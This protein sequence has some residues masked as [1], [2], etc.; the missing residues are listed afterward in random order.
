VRFVDGGPGDDGEEDGGG[1]VGLPPEP[2]TILAPTE[3]DVIR[4][5]SGTTVAAGGYSEPDGDA[6]AATEFEVWDV[7]DG[8]RVERIWRGEVDGASDP[9]ARSLPEGTFEGSHR[10]Q[11]RL[12]WDD[13]YA[14]RA[15][16]VDARGARSDWSAEVFFRTDLESW[17]IYDT[18]RVPEFH[19]DV[20]AAGWAELWTHEACTANPYVRASFT[21]EG[22][23]YDCVGVRLKGCV[24]SFRSLDRK[25]G[26][27]IKF[28]FEE[29][30]VEQR[31]HG[32]RG[33]TLNNGVQD[34]TA[35]HQTLGYE[36][37]RAAGVPAPRANSANL[38]VNGELWGLYANV[39]SYNVDFIEQWF[40]DST[41]DLYEQGCG[42]LWD[43][44][45]D[46]YD[47]E[48]NE[49]APEGRDDLEEMIDF[50][51]YEPD[52]TWYTNIRQYVDYDQFLTFSAIESI[53]NHWDGYT[54]APNNFRIYHDPTTDLFTFIPSGIDQTYLGD[55]DFYGEGLW[56]PRPLMGR[57]CMDS[58]EC[59]AD[60]T[61]ALEAV[62][63]LLEEIDQGPRAQRLYDV[64]APSVLADPRKEYDR[65]WFNQSYQNLLDWIAARPDTA[66]L[67]LP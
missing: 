11:G 62:V 67:Q 37:F 17:D 13:P 33:L 50:L 49:D 29:C 10:D 39:E 60:F 32:L 41:G 64:I 5:V 45:E 27:K 18:E 52:G 3:G 42:D 65:F 2:P 48:T 59:T 53:L 21:Y 58:A 16:F 36:Y 30:D 66:R 34:S 35:L 22:E 12:G 25:A 38:T 44:A 7:V 63:V 6:L 56:G 47:L 24:G 57:R 19:L 20:D 31:F 23:V 61:A 1:A 55:I 8:A 15:R 28:N 4:D 43:G 46:C 40:D 14:I 54:Y 9:A 26:F 51:N